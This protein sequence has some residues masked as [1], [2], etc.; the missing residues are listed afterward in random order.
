MELELVGTRTDLSEVLEAY[1]ANQRDLF[2]FVVA[3]TKSHAAAEDVVQE[4]FLRLTR[5][6]RRGRYPENV[7]P[8]LFHVAANLVRSGFRQQSVAE[9]FRGR[10][11]FEEA[12]E[13]PEWGA[14]RGEERDRVRLALRTLPADARAAL[15]LS[16]EGFSGDEIA[17][18]LGRSEG[19][20]RTLLWRSRTAL[21]ST[22]ADE[23]VVR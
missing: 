23:R 2:G 18:M 17:R 1:D 7:R 9:R 20:T 16:A 5:E 12:V 3:T 15:M 13:G 14:L 11:G 19:S 8:W 4:T 21:R 6:H 22:L 10:F